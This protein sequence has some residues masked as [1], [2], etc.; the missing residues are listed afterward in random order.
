VGTVTEIADRYIA[1]YMV[2]NPVRATR[3]GGDLT[4]TELTDYSPD[5]RGAFVDLYRR[6][7]TALAAAEPDDEAERLGRLFLLDQVGG[8]LAVLEAHEHEREVSVLAAPPASVRAVFDLVPRADADDWGRIAERMGN[9][10]DAIEGYRRTLEAG[11]GTGRV[12]AKRQAVAVAAQCRT[13]AAGWFRDFVG[14]YGDGPLQPSLSRAADAA[15]E[16]YGDLADW[17]STT[18]LAA[19]TDVDCV[20]E[21]RYVVAQRAM[22]GITPDLDETYAWGWEELRRLQS[23]QREECDR[24]IPGADFDEVRALLAT[25][26][27][28]AVHGVDAYREWLQEVSDD[29]TRRLNGTQFDIPDALLRCD[30][31]IPPAG[32]AAAP[33]YSAP[34]EDLSQPG[35]TW[36]PITP[37]DRTSFPKWDQVTIAYHEAVP[38]HHLQLGMTRVLPLMRAHRL[39]FHSAHGEGWA[40]YAERLADELGF[41]DVPDTRLGFLSSQAFR[42]V[43]V[44]IDIGLH[45]G[46]PLPDGSAWT[47]ERAVEELMAASGYERPF[48][49]SEV[50]RYLSWPAQATTYKLGERA[51]LAGRD[52]ARARLGAS[53]ELRRWHADALALGAL[54]LADLGAELVGCG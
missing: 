20:G 50:L 45:T 13:W 46:R 43:R 18:Y 54:G 14:Q 16:S 17:L 42:A 7:V 32:T 33:Y 34:S 29:A 53:F 5:G 35:R 47:Y 41:F 10:P 52:A 48:C 26:P 31:S 25:D 27:A 3:M 8:Q 39:G 1:E 38:G 15:C 28:R 24:I 23:E 51:W 2:L 40:L 36:F 30:I 44:V 19:A 4:T 22:L 49:E 12:A 6:T 11:I 9:V 37:P 21:E